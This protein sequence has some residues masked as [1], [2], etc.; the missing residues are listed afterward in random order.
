MTGF[1]LDRPGDFTLPSTA[2]DLDH[3]TIMISGTTLM[4][5]GVTVRNDMPFDLDTCAVAGSKIGVLRD[6]DSIHFF[7][8]G[9]DQGTLLFANNFLINFIINF[10]F[11]SHTHKR[12]GL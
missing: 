7:I 11:N 2:T 12:S 6:N 1:D 10:N 5:N 9:V 4:F 8:N 3:D